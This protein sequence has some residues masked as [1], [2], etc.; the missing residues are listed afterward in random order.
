MRVYV[1]FDDTDTLDS[2]YGTGKLV[3]RFERVL[4]EGCS[5][6]GVVRQQLLFDERIPY[7]S[8]NSSACAIID[9]PD[10]SLMSELISRA[11]DHI[12]QESTEGRSSNACICWF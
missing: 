1:G 9:L 10:P 8:H 12:E 4:P 2:E 11:V 3:R 7:T 5:L 6:W